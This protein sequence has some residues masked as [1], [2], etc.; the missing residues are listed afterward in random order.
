MI[1]APRTQRPSLREAAAEVIGAFDPAA[2]LVY[3]AAA[4][5]E[6]VEAR[7]WADEAVESVGMERYL[8]R[9]VLPLLA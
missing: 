3:V 5:G 1:A 6:A 4:L 2:P 7:G 8:R 9:V